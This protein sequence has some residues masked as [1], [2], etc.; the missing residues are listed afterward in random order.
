[1]LELVLRMREEKT[2][3]EADASLPEHTSLDLYGLQTSH[4]LSTLCQRMWSQETT[5]MEVL[6]Q[7]YASLDLFSLQNVIGDNSMLEC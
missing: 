3:R 1:M 2:L 7:V 4:P 5:R 6:C